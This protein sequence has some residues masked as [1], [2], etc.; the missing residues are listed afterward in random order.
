[1]LERSGDDGRVRDVGETAN[2]VISDESED[3]SERYVTYAR[4]WQ[5]IDDRTLRS[6]S[7]L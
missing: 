7:S 6:D 5:D 4:Y 1:M 2:T 3:K